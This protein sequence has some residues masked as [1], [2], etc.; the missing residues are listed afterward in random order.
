MEVLLD[1]KVLFKCLPGVPFCDNDRDAKEVA[2]GKAIFMFQMFS[3][4]VLT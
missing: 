2:L 1:Q 3:I 4:R